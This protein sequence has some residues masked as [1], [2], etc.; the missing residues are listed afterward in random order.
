MATPAQD[1]TKHFEDTFDII[2]TITDIEED[3]SSYTG[4]WAAA[5]SPSASAPEILVAKGTTTPFDNAPVAGGITFSHAGGINKV[6]VSVT[7]SD[8]IDSAGDTDKLYTGSFYHEL[9]IGSNVNGNDSVVI[10]TGTI[11]IAEDLFNYR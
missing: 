3:I 10:A 11:T 7:Q 2:F 8:Y 6:T 4:Y 1:F 5:L 9:T